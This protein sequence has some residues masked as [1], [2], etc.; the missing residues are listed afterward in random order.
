MTAR[1]HQ[2]HGDISAEMLPSSIKDGSRV[3][4]KE[5]VSTANNQASR[6]C[7]ALISMSARLCEP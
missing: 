3:L 1:Q 7:T 2:L 4:D 5:Q 6:P